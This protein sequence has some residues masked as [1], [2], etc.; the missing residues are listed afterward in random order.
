MVFTFIVSEIIM[1]GDAKTHRF[2]HFSK[3]KNAKF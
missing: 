1:S 3:F 2:F